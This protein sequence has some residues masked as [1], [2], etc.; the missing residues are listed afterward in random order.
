MIACSTFPLNLICLFIHDFVFS[1]PPPLLSGV[2][3]QKHP[4]LLGVGPHDGHAIVSVDLSLLLLL[5]FPLH[6]FYLPEC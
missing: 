6:L 2:L 5:L 4:D 3:F 1:N